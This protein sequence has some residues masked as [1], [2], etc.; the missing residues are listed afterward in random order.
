MTRVFGLTIAM[1]LLGACVASGQDDT[2]LD[3]HLFYKPSCARCEDVRQMLTEL[4]REHPELK[5]H[6]Y[7]VDEPENVELMMQFYDRYD[8]PEERWVGYGAVFLGDRWWTSYPEIHAEVP[9]TVASMLGKP[10]PPPPEPEARVDGHDRVMEVFERFGPVTVAVAGLADGVNPCALAALVFLVSFLTIAGRGQ[11]EILATGLLFAAGVFLAYLGVGLGLFR[12]LQELS[13]F[14]AVSKLLYPAMAAGTLVLTALSFRDYLRARSGQPQQMSLRLP[15]GLHRISHATIRRLLGG[16]AFLAL[17]FA[18]GAA[19][20]LLELVCTGQ[21]YLPTLVYVS[22]TQGLSSRATP[23]LLLYVTMFTLPVV[24]LSIAV[25]RG[26]TS[27]R[28]R[29]WARQHAA[30]SKLALT[31]VFAILTAALVASSLSFW[32]V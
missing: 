13:G 17:A 23:L 11:G 28:I 9:A 19:V 8:V 10:V 16:P 20:S 3:L 27:E 25:W 31:V 12:G 6:V 18:A 24:A 32:L 4:Q 22:S 2:A 26:A 5:V 15:T 1:S 7:S 30:A 21:I 29:R 14:S